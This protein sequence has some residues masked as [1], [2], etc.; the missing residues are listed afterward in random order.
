[1]SLSRSVGLLFLAGLFSKFLSVFYRVPLSYLLGAEGIGLYQMSYPAFVVMV[2]VA[3]GG[4]PF[5]ITKHIA[6]HLAVGD[7][8][9]AGRLF[10]VGQQLLWLRG[11]L[12]GLFFY[13]F[14]PILALK[15]LGDPRS[16]LPLKMLAPAIFFI[17]VEGSLRGYFQGLQQHSILAKAQAFE[18]LCRVVIMLTLS[19]LLLPYG[20]EYAAAGAAAGA[21]GGSLCAIV[22]L[23]GYKAR[24]F[25]SKCFLRLQE[26]SESA[27]MLQC[28]GLP[29]ML[30]SFIMPVMQMIDAAIVPLRLQASGIPIHLATALFGQHAGMALSLVALPTVATRALTTA[31]VPNLA[32]ASARKN[33]TL[34]TNRM[35]LAIRITAAISLPATVGLYILAQPICQ[36]LFGTP[37]AA[38]PLQWLAFGTVGLCMMETNGSLLHALGKGQGAVVALFAGAVVNASVDYYAC[39]L[40]ALNIRGAALGTGLGFT[41]A[42][43]LSFL[44]LKRYLPKPFN[45]GALLFPLLASLIMAPVVKWAFD[46]SFSRGWVPMVVLLWAVG[47]G[48][49][50]YG[51]MA[52]TTGLFGANIFQA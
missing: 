17:C 25:N 18:Q 19:F 12:L 7:K 44:F 40:P 35:M 13:L 15:V 37:E 28:F 29:V 2:I 8:E 1:M 32:A 4:L 5:A 43:A 20:L 45:Y 6:Q 21:A 41:V 26:W 22:F 11:I 31:L 16:E 46:F 30:G 38:I 42:A 23:Q 34:V 51:L 27:R 48:A 39:A 50:F 33:Q 52:L 10:R 3:T 14:A 49:G 9:K 47:V 24:R 36:V